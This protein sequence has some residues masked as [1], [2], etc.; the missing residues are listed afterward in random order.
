MHT[1]SLLAY[2]RKKIGTKNSRKYRKKILIPAIIYKH[3]KKTL[4]INIS[5]NI[6]YP[7]FNK[8]NIYKKFFLLIIKKQKILTYIK[9]IQNH[10]FKPKILHIDFIYQ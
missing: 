7:I 8:I 4:L 2:L 5:H 3:H 10:P 6:F 9:N 1:I